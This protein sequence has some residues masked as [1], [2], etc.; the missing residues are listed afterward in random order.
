MKLSNFHSLIGFLA[1]ITFTHSAN[2][3]TAL[4]LGAEAVTVQ[5]QT[6]ANTTVK[7]LAYYVPA[8]KLDKTQSKVGCTFAEDKYSPNDGDKAVALKSTLNADGT[9]SLAI[10]TSGI[11]GKCA[12]TLDS[13]YM[14]VEAPKVF[15][16]IKLQS[17]KSIAQMDEVLKDVGGIGEYQDFSALND[18]YCDLNPEYDMGLCESKD[19]LLSNF[20][21]I[22]STAATYTLN[23]K[24]IA[25]KPNPYQ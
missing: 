12:Y 24:G 20:Y 8:Y 1:V 22:S 7:A 15:E 21:G 13:V 11:R 3:D 9:Y 16:S 5:G 25:E 18:M 2:A 10:P 17:A 14:D 23:I 19:G 6:Q 4:K